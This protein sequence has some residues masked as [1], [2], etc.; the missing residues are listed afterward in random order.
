MPPTDPM[1]MAARSSD[2]RPLPSAIGSIPKSDAAELIRTGRNFAADAFNVAARGAIPRP[3]STV[4]SSTMRMAALT[5]TPTS[6]MPASSP[7]TVNVVCVTQSAA[8][9]PR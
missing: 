4:R 3:R 5:T 6:M 2:P 7:N 9:I 1:P 8:N